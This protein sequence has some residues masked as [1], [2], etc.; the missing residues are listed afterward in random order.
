MLMNRVREMGTLLS[1]SRVTRH[2]PAVITVC[3]SPTFIYHMSLGFAINCN[4]FKNILVH[5]SSFLSHAQN[6][7]CSVRMYCLCYLR[8]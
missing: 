3:R 8:I 2:G 7:F 4:R 6:H 5:W 1:E